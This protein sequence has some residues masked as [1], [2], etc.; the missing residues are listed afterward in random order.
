MK[1]VSRLIVHIGTG[2][3]ASTTLQKSILPQLSSAGK[4]YFVEG[5]LNEMIL[6]IYRTF[7]I[8]GDTSHDSLRRK[9]LAFRWKIEKLISLKSVP[10]FISLECLHGWD[11]ECWP[12]MLMLNKTM[13]QGLADSVE[14][15]ISFRSTKPYLESVYMQM[16]HQGLMPSSPDLY[17][18][19]SQSYKIARNFLG[20]CSMGAD[21]FCLDK[22]I[23]KDLFELY[24]SQF[25]VVYAFKMEE[26]LNL[27]F[28]NSLCIRPSPRLVLSAKANFSNHNRSYSALAYEMTILREK[29]LKIF[30]VRSRSS[31]DDTKLRSLKE[32][33]GMSIAA[34]SANHQYSLPLRLILKAT[35]LSPLRK[36]LVPIKLMVAEHFNWHFLM[37]RYINN[38]MPYTK[39]AINLDLC[40]YSLL[41]GQNSEFLSTGISERISKK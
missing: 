20:R 2:K 14:I 36:F 22:L 3:T 10:C 37:K 8:F 9:I 21:I 12:E 25:N 39:A 5:N 33:K 15:M 28:L 13:F 27:E 18:L 38:F 19:D 23:Y 35:K 32:I 1:Y 17:F 11:P 29:I 16:I 6:E 26:I 4:I 34:N 41:D 24:A 30:V 7:I 31:L 40:D